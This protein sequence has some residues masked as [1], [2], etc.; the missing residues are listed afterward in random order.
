[1]NETI[2][3][4]V[5]K[6]TIYNQAYRQG[7]PMVSDVEYDRLVEK[8]RDLD[9]AHPYLHAVEPESFSGKKEIRHPFPMLSTDK[10]Y[11]IEALERFVNRVAKT[12]QELA[13]AQVTYR[14]TPKLD[15]L[16]GRD[17]GQAFASRGNGEIGYDISSAFQKGVLPIGGRGHGIGEIVIRQSYFEANLSTEFEHPRNMVVGIISSDK[18]NE[19]AQQALQDQMV[20]F[21]PYNQLPFWEGH[22]DDML[23]DLNTIISDLANQTDYPMDGAV[24]EVVNPD[25]RGAMGATAHHYRWQIAIKSKGATAITEVEGVT[26]QVGRT[27]NITPVMQVK[28]V[29]LSGATIRRVTAHHAGM[30][31][32]EKIG[33]GSEVEIIRSG[34]VIPKLEKVLK[35][36]Q[37][38]T[39]PLECPVCQTQLTWQKDF[40]RCDNRL[41]QAQIEQGISHW[42]KTLGNADW[43]G[44][45][46][47]QKI[48]AKGF[49]SLEKIYAMTEADF[50]NIGFGPIQSKN[51]AE[52]L[53]ISRTK[54]VE[55]W[56][57]LAA[58]GIT[59]LGKG[60]SRKLLSHMTLE[61]LLDADRQ[62]ILSIDGF[63][64]VT[65]DTIHNGIQALRSTIDHLLSLNFNLQKTALHQELSFLKSAISD[66]GIVFTGKMQQGSREDMQTQARQLGARVQTA[67]SGKTDILVCG[68]NV[69]QTKISKARKQGV[70]IL[71]EQAYLELL[72]SKL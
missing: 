68:E 2:H 45:K 67:V 43:F 60:D 47:I 50:V 63:G 9:P 37:E 24:A 54:A 25:I 59:N 15:G 58:L 21:V 65:S 23:R 13:V 35:T 17:D 3:E 72:N 46:S 66:K 33:P 32:K 11:T 49:D 31:V 20:H 40:L 51:L 61:D 5:E 39:L 64:E 27:G 22:A 71:S 18:L 14:I 30:V 42:F 69:G 28:P 10:A 8:L 7:A 48:V 1:M 52:A 53:R 16:A 19:S 41:C 44:I 70:T 29:L 36:S 26:W 55:D 34:E 38:V 4:I 57:F 12:A 6:L 62:T 56:R